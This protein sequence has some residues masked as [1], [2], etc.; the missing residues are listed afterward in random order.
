MPQLFQA[1]EKR[2]YIQME[3]LA[4]TTQVILACSSYQAH[5]YIDTT[6]L[7]L[8]TVQAAL[9]SQRPRD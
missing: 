6:P 3:N 9:E 5:S 2:K 7:R 1:E 8:Y 4:F